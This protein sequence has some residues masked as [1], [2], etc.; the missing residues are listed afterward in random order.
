MK[1]IA[2][3]LLVLLILSF[4]LISCVANV[5]E[6]ADVVNSTVKV[7]LTD[8][9]V[10]EVDSLWVY[11]KDFTYTY[12]TIDGETVTSTPIS[13]EKEYDILSLAGTE[14]TL[15]NFEIPENSTLVNLKMTVKDATVTIAG[16]DHSVILMKSDILIPNVDINIGEGGELVL[17]FD[18]V[19]SLHQMGN[20]DIYKLSPVLKPTF[21]RG[22]ANDL[23]L[24]KGNIT[25]NSTPVSKA[26]VTISD[27]S[28]LL[29]ITF[30]DKNGNF[31]LGKYKNGNYTINVYTNINL[32]DE[33]VDLDFSLYTPD[34]TK[35]ITIDNSDLDLNID[36]SKQN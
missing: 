30:S 16:E 2:Y 18:V 4:S 31:H 19:R 35:I 6:D 9:P 11:I 28:T 14:T 23:Y 1:K 24:V 3:I 27:D 20:N 17:D 34:A 33:D 32:P 13:I 8:R 26:I 36:I 5:N 21:R 15:F 25:D 10:S 29:R 12:E 22:N 7:L